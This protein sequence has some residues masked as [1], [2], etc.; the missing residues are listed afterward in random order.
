V[1]LRVCDAAGRASSGVK[2]KPNARLASACEVDL[3][4]E[5][6]QELEV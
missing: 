5:G 3:L 2:I 1:I 6:Y 4:E